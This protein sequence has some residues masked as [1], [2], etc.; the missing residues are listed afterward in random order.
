VA[1]VLYYRHK[2]KIDLITPMVSGDKL[3]PAGTPAS[4]D[5][6]GTRVLALVVL[7]V[8]AVGVWVLLG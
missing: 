4:K 2:R 6:V 8:I 7:G 1:T 3:L 5:S